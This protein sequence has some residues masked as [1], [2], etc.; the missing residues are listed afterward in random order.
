MLP[1]HD[2]TRSVT[3]VNW[4]SLLVNRQ[5]VEGHRQ[6]EDGDSRPEGVGVAD[7]AL[8]PSLFAAAA[9]AGFAA[10]EFLFPY[11]HPP[12]AIAR[13]LSQN[14]LTLALFNLPPRN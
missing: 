9:D 11:D 2:V 13:C 7:V 3:E 4:P 14:G 12:D 5:I 6:D 8:P 10:V 1:I